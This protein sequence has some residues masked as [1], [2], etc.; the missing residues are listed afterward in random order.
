MYEYNRR[1]KIGPLT[2]LFLFLFSG[3]LVGLSVISYL[4]KGNFWDILPYFCIPII[5]LSLILAIYNLAKRCNAGLVFMLFFII[6]TIGLVLSSI[7]G[8]FALQRE[9]GHFLEEKDYN[10]AIEKYDQLLKNYPNSQYSPDALKEISSAYYYDNQYSSALAS[11]NIAFE[12]NII[13]PEELHI[14]DMLSNIHF[15]I[16]ETHTEKN[17]YLDAAD[18]Y[19]RSAIILKQIKSGFPDTNEAFIAEYK[20]PQYLF[21]ASKNYNKHGAVKD[22]IEI[23]QEILADYIESDF[24]QDAL[25]AIEDAYIAQAIILASDS[26][27]ADAIEWF[28][29]YLE[30]CPDP[31]R[32]LTFNSKIT[33]IFKGAPP[34]SIKQSADAAF[35]Q[36]DYFTAIFLYEVLIEYNPGY[37]KQIS[38]SLVNLKMILAQSSPYNEILQSAAGKYVNTPEIAILAFQNNMQ[39]SLSAY[40]KGP[41]NYIVEIPPGEYMETEIVPGEY[42]VLVEPQKKDSLPYMGNMLFEEY[43]KY[44]EVFDIAEEE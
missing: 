14:M 32:T 37:L 22:E 41:E 29:K 2:I 21:L 7:F 1:R 19:L 38:G 12:K 40:I 10:N 11:F 33:K 34:S 8:P 4:D 35:L 9:A 13:D 42:S 28:A 16:A 15:K 3:S 20:L 5:V 6:F 25:N 18:S 44:T 31:E 17:E 30:L 23:L 26:K 39:E 24:Y 27:Y 43:R 36:E